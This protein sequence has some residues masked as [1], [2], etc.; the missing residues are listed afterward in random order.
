MSLLYGT[1]RFDVLEDD[2][3]H[4]QRTYLDEVTDVY[5]N[6]DNQPHASFQTSWECIHL[7]WPVL[8]PTMANCQ[9]TA[10]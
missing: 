10:P 6:G 8:C 3:L 1:T 2:V 7:F 5:L 9:H 4:I